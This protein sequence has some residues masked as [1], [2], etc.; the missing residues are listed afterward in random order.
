MEAALQNELR[1]LEAGIRKTQKNLEKFE[2]K[3]K[4]DTNR[5]ISDYADGKISENLDYAEWIG[6]FRM[7]ERLADKSEALKSVHIED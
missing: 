2:A 4:M 1:L 7:L 3:Y 6:E 5:F